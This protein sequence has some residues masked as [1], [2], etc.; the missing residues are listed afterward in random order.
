MRLINAASRRPLQW[1]PRWA[2]V[3][4]G[5]LL[6]GLAAAAPAGVVP[7][8]RPA[9]APRASHTVLVMGD[10]LSAGYGLGA[11]Q[12]WVPLTAQR[13]AQDKPGWQVVN[14]SISGETTSGGAARVVGEVVRVRPAVVI[15]ELGANDGLR[16]LPVRQARHN[17]AYMIGAAQGIG[18]KVLLVGMR[19]PPNYGPDYTQSFERMYRDLAQQFHTAF[20]PFLLEPIMREQNA[21]Q[22]DD[23]HP[24]ARVQPLIRDYVWK[25]LAPM[26]DETGQP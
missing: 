19:M 20:V 11:T 5:L 3:L 15:I 12:G 18:A 26:L 2:L 17:L 6:A 22:Q 4:A 7:A 1:V 10:S 13:I 24:V 25:A 8:V 16:G 23:M 9:H 14:A 21:F